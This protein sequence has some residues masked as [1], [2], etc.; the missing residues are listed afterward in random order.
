MF[1][2]ND[3]HD[4]QAMFD[5]TSW[6]SPKTREKLMKS[7]APIFYEHVFRQI[8]EAPFSVLYGDTGKPNFPVNILLS[9]EYIKH[10][11]DCSDLEILDD[12]HFDYLV[13]YAVGNRTLGERSLGERT[14][15]NFRERVYR[16]SVDN[17]GK[18]D[19]LFGQ[20]IKLVNDFA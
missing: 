5:S 17:P 6:M 11:R 8:D 4:Q 16:Y 9:L 14:V 18:D 15:Y 2:P 1:R 12:Y 20:F 13:N 3:N 10:M 7:W 19:I